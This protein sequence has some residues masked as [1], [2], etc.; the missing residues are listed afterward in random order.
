MKLNKKY[1]YSFSLLLS[2]VIL[3]S[4]GFSVTTFDKNK[5]IDVILEH[6]MNDHKTHYNFINKSIPYHCFE[7]IGSRDK[8]K[9]TS[10][11]RFFTLL[12]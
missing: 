9:Y 11:W 3:F 1:Y 12:Y 4:L 8:P 10:W 5:R 7:D 6:N 2:F